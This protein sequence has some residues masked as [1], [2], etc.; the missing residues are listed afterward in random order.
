MY[1][2]FVGVPVLA[3]VLAAR[4]GAGL[5]S[6]R[7]LGRVSRRAPS[8]ISPSQPRIRRRRLSRLKRRDLEPYA[9]PVVELRP[10]SLSSG[11]SRRCVIL[12]PT[13]WAFTSSAPTWVSRYAPPGRH[14]RSRGLRRA[15]RAPR[16]HRRGAQVD[17]GAGGVGEGGK[18]GYVAVRQRAARDSSC[19]RA[20]SYCPVPHVLPHIRPLTPLRVA[21]M[22]STS[23]R[24][25]ANAVEAPRRRGWMSARR[26][27]SEP[28]RASR[29][30]WH[31]G[32]S[33]A[34]AIRPSRSMN[35]RRCRWKRRGW[36]QDC[37]RRHPR[38][39]PEQRARV[40]QRGS[41]AGVVLADHVRGEIADAQLG[42]AAPHHVARHVR[43]AQR[44][45]ARTGTGFAGPHHSR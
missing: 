1:D 32:G 3:W 9:L 8:P 17:R 23:I 36:R 7:S 33:R 21:A 45:H 35:A 42:D 27:E 40:N 30:R 29:D 10:A 25:D 24:S 28:N 22:F 4:A 11:W 18:D 37:Q 16:R 2:T 34:R 14:P 13:R 19:H 31:D 20:P 15:G 39:E 6:L 26:T 44:L 38:L 43:D 5:R 41:W 12:F